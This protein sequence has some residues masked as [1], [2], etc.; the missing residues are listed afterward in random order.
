MAFDEFIRPACLSVDHSYAWTFAIAAG[1]G[2]SSFGGFFAFVVS[3]TENKTTFLNRLTVRLESK[4]RSGALMKV[5]LRSIDDD[6]CHLT[7]QVN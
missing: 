7:Y 5:T 4:R 2:Q 3:P 6:T 1:F